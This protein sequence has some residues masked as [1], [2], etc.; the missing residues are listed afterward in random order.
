MVISY[1]AI[2]GLLKGSY[3]EER[4]LLIISCALKELLFIGKGSYVDERALLI[5]S[6]ALKVLLCIGKGSYV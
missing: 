6:C 3:V 5:R 1:N 2:K 4:V